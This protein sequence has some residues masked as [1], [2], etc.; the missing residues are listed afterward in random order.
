MVCYSSRYLGDKLWTYKVE[1]EK[2]LLKLVRKIDRKISSIVI[3]DKFKVKVYRKGYCLNGRL[4]YIERYSNVK[5]IGKCESNIFEDY[6]YFDFEYDTDYLVENNIFDR[7]YEPTRRVLYKYNPEDIKIL[8]KEVSM[9]NK[10]PILIKKNEN[11]FRLIIPVSYYNYNEKYTI[12]NKKYDK[13]IKDKTPYESL[14]RKIKVNYNSYFTRVYYHINYQENNIEIYCRYKH[15]PKTL[16]QDLD[17]KISKLIINY[18]NENDIN[19]P[20]YLFVTEEI[21]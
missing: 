8:I 10:E 16:I 9:I 2:L 13:I 4:F 14:I 18:T 21:L 20:I 17:K 11:I 15:Q 5:C 6:V 19:I 3:K 12:E 7:L 1:Y